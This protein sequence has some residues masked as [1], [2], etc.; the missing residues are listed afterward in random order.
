MDFNE[1]FA[2]VVKPMILKTVYA[3]ASARRYYIE[4]I[5]QDRISIRLC[6]GSDLCGT[7]NRYESIKAGLPTTQGTLWPETGSSS[8]GQ[9]L[10]CTFNSDGF[11][12]LT[13]DHSVFIRGNIV[14]V[15]YVDDLLLV[16]PDID[17]LS[18]V[19]K[20]L[21]KSFQMSDLGASTFYLGM[22]VTRDREAQVLSQSQE[23]YIK[24]IL[25]TKGMQD[26]KPASTLI[27][28]NNRLE[29][30]ESGYEATPEFRTR[31]QSIA[32]SL[33]YAM[34]GTR[35]DIAFA[36]SVISR[37]GSNPM[38]TH[39]GAVKRILRYLKGSSHLKLVYHG[40]LKHLTGYTD[41]TG[42]EIMTL[43]DQPPGTFSTLGA[44]R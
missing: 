41:S 26:S 7:S 36:V 11:K 22:S 13:A 28:A 5:H 6:R 37:Y 2:S 38:P 1:T 20:E 29:K 3:I 44:V 35:P 16:G 19:K 25:R 42:P 8:L 39:Y 17:D 4:Q 10:V 23:T 34:L 31:Y 43:E 32:G 15:I 9:D 33:M 18:S 40:D 14:I 21:S 27:E 30:A 24:K 12:P